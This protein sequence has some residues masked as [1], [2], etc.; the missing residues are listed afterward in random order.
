MKQCDVVVVGAGPGGYVAAIRAAQRG[1]K[2]IVVERRE[3]GGVCLNEGCI[4]T[5][6]FVHTA[7][8]YRKIRRASEFG[9][10]VDGV[11]LDLPGLLKHKEKVIKANVAGIRNLFKSNG[12]EVVAGDAVVTAPGVV[13]VDREEIRAKAIIIATGGAPAQL[14]GLELNGKTVIGSS[15]ALEMA[16]IPKR[17]AVIGA[18][19]MGS[20]FACIWN[21]F[22]ADITLIEMMPTLLP[23]SDEE[24][25]TR[26]AEVFTK[27]GIDVRTGTKVSSLK[28]GKTSVRL[29]LNGPKTETIEVD[30][31][32]V[33]IGL[34]CNSEVVTQ[35][36]GLGVNVEGPRAG[37]GVNNRL[38]TSV[39]GIYAIGDVI[40]K[41]WLAH[42]ASAE[43]LVAAANA[44]GGQETIDYR[45]VPAC[46][47]TS[48][49]VA[50]VGLTEKKARDAG[51]N[52]KIGR[53]RY[54]G[55]GRAHAIGETEGMVKIVGDAATDEVLGVHIMGAEA[56]ELISAAAVAM[57]MEATVEELADTI[58][59]HPTLSETIKEAAED[60]LGVGIHTPAP[61]KK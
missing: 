19:A 13:K 40:N 35:T 18:G 34:K 5:K 6:T 22:G 3:L 48:P 17:I 23:V 37:I 12:I 44:T 45:V 61:R 50:G 42:G 60:Y 56:G 51:I 32:L 41:T 39:R 26:L 28:A 52:V 9:I 20:E 7:E 21:A 43:G 33:G 49:E 4:P 36:P 47:F 10:R 38:E 1:A 29:D 30:M 46:N 54:M 59:T 53:F 11:A 31:V 8:L 16:P 24:L 25:T 58:Q 27:R 57:Q 55:S 14:P 2:T 15:K